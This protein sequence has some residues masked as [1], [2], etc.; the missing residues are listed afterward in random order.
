LYF[1][2]QN[3]IKMNIA[4]WIFQGILAAMML[5]PGLMK[6]ASTKEDLKVKGNGRMD[7]VDD[8]SSGN[9][10][11]IGF[12]EI[13]IG[14]GLILPML[15]GIAPFLTPWAAVGAICTMIGAIILHVKRKDGAPAIVTNLVILAIAVF[16]A[17]G[18]FM[19]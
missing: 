15:V 14:L 10:K 11:L 13:L 4:L 19:L 18:R 12:V 1:I 8:L 3:E 17:Y 16:V 2:N 5:L 7:W 9:V 6:A